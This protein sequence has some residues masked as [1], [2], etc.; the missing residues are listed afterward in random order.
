MLAA[1]DETD[2]PETVA[3]S[4]PN[5]CCSCGCDQAVQPSPFCDWCQLHEHLEYCFERICLGL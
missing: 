2:T 5:V 1:V 3:L 4:T